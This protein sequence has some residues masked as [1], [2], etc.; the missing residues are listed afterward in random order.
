MID[1]EWADFRYKHK[2]NPQEAFE[3]MVPLSPRDYRERE[4]KNLNEWRTAA[5]LPVKRLRA[6]SRDLLSLQNAAGIIIT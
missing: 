1:I 4:E 5:G 3:R 6:T 2:K